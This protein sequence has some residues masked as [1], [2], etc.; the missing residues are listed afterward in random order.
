[1]SCLIAYGLRKVGQEPINTSHDSLDL[2]DNADVANA[3]DLAVRLEL[4]TKWVI[5]SLK[6]DRC[7]FDGCWCK[8]DFFFND[9]LQQGVEFIFVIAEFFRIE[10]QDD[11]ATAL[12]TQERDQA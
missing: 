12:L 8:Y 2:L 10:D 6:R 9:L 5:L 1:M 7:R 11:F 4:R 3:K